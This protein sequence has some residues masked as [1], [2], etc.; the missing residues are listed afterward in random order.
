MNRNQDSSKKEVNKNKYLA[1][2]ISLGEISSEEDD[3]SYPPRA[4]K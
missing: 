1:I 3:I 2:K 4:S